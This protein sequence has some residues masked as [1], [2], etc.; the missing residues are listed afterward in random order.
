MTGNQITRCAFTVAIVFTAFLITNSATQG[1]WVW[2]A[3]G[4][5]DVILLVVALYV[6]HKTRDPKS[7][8]PSTVQS[9]ISAGLSRAREQKDR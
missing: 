4:I 1:V 7:K 3:I 2:V 9:R 6:L 5:A 8:Y